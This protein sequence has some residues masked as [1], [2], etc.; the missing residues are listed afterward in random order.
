M[1]KFGLKDTD[2]A[3]IKSAIAEFSVIKDA[4]IY[5]SRAK[6]NFKPGSDVD[7]ALFGDV[8]FNVISTLNRKLNEEGTMPYFFDITAYETSENEDLK[9][10]IDRVGISILNA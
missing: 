5:G 6:G 8:D 9:A 10:H 1:T 4:R 2:I 3:T 7:I